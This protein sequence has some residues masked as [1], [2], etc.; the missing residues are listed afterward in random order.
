MSATVAAALKKV[1]VAV[2]TDPKVLKK[3]GIIL[4]VILIVLFLPI[5][6]VIAIFSGDVKIDPNRFRQI[7]NENL[8]EEDQERM[9]T[10]DTVFADIEKIMTD[11]G[12]GYVQIQKARVLCS[13]PLYPYID[14]EG[15]ADKLIGCFE[16]EQTDEQLIEKVN[17]AFATKIKTN[18]FK[19]V[20]DS[21]INRIVTVA[22]EQVGNV[23]GKKFWSWYGLGERVEWCACFV[24]W[25]EDQCGY[26]ESGTMPKFS[27]CE[28]GA[29]WFKQQG[30]WLDE[31]ATP[32]P[33][34]LIFY[35]WDNKEQSGNQDGHADHVGIVERVENGTVYTIEGNISDSCKQISVK[36]GHYEIL[37][38][39]T[40][41]KQK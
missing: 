13:I 30:K 4:L 19:T 37:G 18:E 32:E 14:S 10:R 1:A 23:G 36:A 3:I 16:T 15:F 20:C 11:K 33:G 41:N 40:Y 17:K 6:A 34:M 7:V 5:C 9:A 28:G 8:S 27:S 24:S 29:K 26:I 39:G 21:T 25:C 2:L 35:D 12:Y 31:K 22:K 38:Y